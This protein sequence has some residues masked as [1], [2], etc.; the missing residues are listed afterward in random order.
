MIEGIFPWDTILPHMHHN[1][2]TCRV[3]FS[4]GVMTTGSGPY[5]EF[6]FDA[7]LEECDV[8]VFSIS[9]PVKSKLIIGRDDWDE[10][11]ILSLIQSR[12][13][14][15]LWVYSQEMVV[16][17]LAIGTDI[18]DVCSRDELV[19][20]GEGHPAL[21]YLMTDMGFDWPTTEVIQGINR[22]DDLGDIPN[23]GVLSLMGYHV[24]RQGGAEKTRRTILDKIMV[25]DLSRYPYST[26]QNIEDWS[27]PSSA[28]RL[29]KLANCLAAFTRLRKRST[30][31]DNREAIREWESDLNYLK[32]YYFRPDSGFRWPDTEVG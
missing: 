15:S 3:I 6:E 16:A 12:A 18:F 9:D 32:T 5:D 19:I 4:L 30:A 29:Q 17:S 23:Q 2:S 24:G 31:F 22:L 14:G 27:N 26:V 21:E 11:L 13:G 28:R 7:F 10:D 8:E 20:F 1:R 25:A